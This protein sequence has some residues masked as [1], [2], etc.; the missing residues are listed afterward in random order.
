[1]Y[2]AHARTKRVKSEEQYFHTSHQYYNF[3]TTTTSFK[4]HRPDKALNEENQ[5]F[6]PKLNPK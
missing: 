4:T 3:S 5:S 1:M 2:T 6:T